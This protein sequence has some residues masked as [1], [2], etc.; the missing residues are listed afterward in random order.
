MKIRK[1]LLTLALIAFLMPSVVAQPYITVFQGK[2]LPGESLSVGGYNIKIVQAINGTY[3]LMVNNGSNTVELRPF[4]FGTKIEL[5][6]VRITLGSYTDGGFLII[7]VKPKLIAKLPAKPGE[8]ASF[9]G[10][11]I[12]V[13]DVS[14]KSAEVSVN[15]IQ[16]ILPINST[17][18]VDLIALEYTEDVINVYVAEKVSKCSTQDYSVFYAVQSLKTSGAVDIPITI[19]SY[20][21]SRLSLPLKI[22]SAPSDWKVGFVYNGFDVDEINIPPKD[23]AT[24]LLHAE[25][26]GKGS[27]KFEIGNFIGEVKISRETGIEVFIPYSTI[28]AEAGRVV[29]APISFKGYGSVR[30]T[31]INI[32]S[33][34]DMYLTNGQY[35]LRSFQIEGSSSANLMIEIPR[36][37]TLGYHNLSFEINGRRYYTGIYIYK[38]YLG[39]PAELHVRLLDTTG[40]PITQGWVSVGNKNLTVTQ[41]GEATFELSPGEYTIKAYAEGYLSKEEKIKLGDGES[42]DLQITLEKAPYYFDVKLQSDVV[43]IQ[44]GM[45]GRLE[46][47][48][49]N[50][51]SKDD[52]YTVE[53]EGLPSGWNYMLSQ[54]SSG[55]V[56]ISTVSLASGS[57]STVYIIISP[58]FTA[59]PG[60]IKGKLVVE[61]RGG[62]KS[63]PITIR[64]IGSYNLHLDASPPSVTIKSGGS[65]AVSL[66][67]TSDMGVVTNVKFSVQA[68]S[69]W[70]VEVVPSTIPR[71]GYAEV[72]GPV[73][74][75]G[76]GMASA[77]L[78]IKVPKS[79][80]AGTYTIKVRATGDQAEADTT[81]AV[82]VVQSSGF[83]YLGVLI[84]I[85][86]FALV[87]WMMRRVGR[88]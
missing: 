6:G 34:W 25:P 26:S 56:P 82:R 23:S 5:K 53:I 40:A 86:A 38:T 14:N 70:E 39:Q 30:F 41:N 13:L 33:G 15:G 76:G 2:L 17:V 22:I 73:K 31:P 4:V 80:P 3:Y 69:G 79:A 46:L 16:K 36:N 61:G 11:T 48:I 32:P 66:H 58:P 19:T 67:L 35:R 9:S 83:T 54:D 44:A 63:I 20:S 12:K 28:E 57:S 81:V 64:I 45:S 50:L 75:I 77:E 8:S 21:N 37:A 68:P 65:S 49:R 24:V 87:I 74:V 71:V 72:N 78:R 29:S 27:V 62:E 85:G 18:T 60:E 59:Q 88:R 43:A 1:A 47:S 7:S 52:E 42:K 51:G 84:L 10:N 55:S